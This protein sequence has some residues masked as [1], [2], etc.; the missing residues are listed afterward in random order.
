M[1]RKDPW[2]SL[3]ENPVEPLHI[4]PQAENWENSEQD[5]AKEE[6]Q[7]AR[8]AAYDQEHPVT[9][10]YVP[11]HMRAIAKQVKAALAGLAYEKLCTESS[12]ALAF[13]TWALAEVRA[14]RLSI[15][16]HPSLS[17]RKMNV[18][19]VSAGKDTWQ[20]S[21]EIPAPPGNKKDKGMYLGWRWDK[22][23]VKQVNAL[24]G[25]IFSPG[26]VVVQLLEFAIRAY[27]SGHANLV[28]SPVDV[29]QNAYLE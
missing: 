13:V 2:S 20:T 12:L 8:R 7:K 17:H 21:Q 5:K 6:A 11:K 16:G 10:F 28:I 26:E 22:D 23:T 15:E 14:G 18:V 9:S 1:P 29:R 3:R 25:E 19:L 27:K 24:A 4:I